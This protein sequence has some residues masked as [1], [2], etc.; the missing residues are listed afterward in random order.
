MSTLTQQLTQALKGTRV[1]K[2]FEAERLAELE[3]ARARKE[4]QAQIAAVHRERQRVASGERWR[5]YATFHGP[6]VRL[7]RTV[8]A[9]RMQLGRPEGYTDPVAALKDPEVTAFAVK[10]ALRCGTWRPFKP[11]PVA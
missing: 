1:S 10:A 6:V 3:R 2:E 11:A 7:S 4:L 9:G 8:L 5:V